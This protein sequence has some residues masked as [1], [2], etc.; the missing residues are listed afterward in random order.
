[1]AGDIPIEREFWL[2]DC[3]VV[4]DQNVIVRGTEEIS[5][6]PRSMALLL[7]LVERQGEMISG[8]EL[9][10][11]VWPANHIGGNTVYKAVNEL[12]S[13]FGDDS[14]HSSFIE[15]RSRHGY[16]L[17]VEP[18]WTHSQSLI[19]PKTFRRWGSLSLASV[20]VVVLLF[21][22][23]LQDKK[24]VQVS[25][26]TVDGQKI[27][28]VHSTI[29]EHDSGKAR[30]AYSQTLMK[31]VEGI[32]GSLETMEVP[33][34][35]NLAKSLITEFELD[36]VVIFS[37]V[38]DGV[39]IEL[40]PAAGGYAHVD[41]FPGDSEL[42]TI[43]DQALTDL[44]TVL[45]KEHKK[46]MQAWGT[47]DIHAYRYAYD[48]NRL[49][50]R[51]DK[52][53][54]VQ[55]VELFRKAI[56]SDPKFGTAYHSI[57]MSVSWIT[58]LAKSTEQ[59]ERGRRDL[60]ELV[61]TARYAGIEDEMIR[62]LEDH[63]LSASAT[64]PLQLVT[65]YS[66]VLSTEPENI[67]ALEGFFALLVGAGLEDEA[68]AYLDAAIDHQV[69]PELASLA[70]DNYASIAAIN[71]PEEQIRLAKI[72]LSKRPNN[73]ISI[74]G[75]VAKMALIGDYVEAELYLERLRQADVEG[76]WAH[77]AWMKLAAARG[78]IPLGSEALEK[79]VND[80]LATSLAIGQT[81]LTLGDVEK[82]LAA[83][84]N[85]EAGLLPIL[86]NFK[87]DIENSFP[88]SVLDD[89][90]YKSLM[91]DLGVGQNWRYY[92]LQQTEQLASI[93]GIPR[94]TPMEQPEVQMI[95]AFDARGVPVLLD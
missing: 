17:K 55:S 31:I 82:G 10:G 70:G 42:P 88:Q 25:I 58:G 35:N 95:A 32:Q 62:D 7:Y 77:A 13:A 8:D 60:Q 83:L 91:N 72:L 87:A 24:I 46:R 47:A 64:H 20:A 9:V 11:Q 48:G 29:D 37:A 67:A 54:M 85:M 21:N 4:P 75:L 89:Y 68:T 50:M 84:R 18:D 90:R 52:N 39:T 49:A 28:F 38:D 57:A 44:N 56:D 27:A 73:V 53:S 2:S 43:V 63:L 3:K 93:T 12:R 61:E 51:A 71:N 33:K 81:F 41:Y 69:D 23:V 15:T 79:A 6:N 1:V 22:F 59:R 80:P 5:I 34:E 36:Q 94:T 76:A 26:A 86:W 40:N 30:L 74:Y 92:L 14:K 66:V 16:R 65:Q 78:V 19:Q 45:D